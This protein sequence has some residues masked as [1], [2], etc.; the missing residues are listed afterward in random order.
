MVCTIVPNQLVWFYENKKYKTNDKGQVVDS[1]MYD[2]CTMSDVT[3]S[4]VDTESQGQNVDTEE[5]GVDCSTCQHADVYVPNTNPKTSTP[6]KSQQ[7]VIVSSQEVPVSSDE[8]INIDINT[9]MSTLG[10]N[11]LAIKSPNPWGDKGVHEISIEIVD[12]LND[13]EQST[14]LNGFEKHHLYIL[15]II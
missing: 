5:M 1:S 12:N 13:S 8:S 11:Q 3:G 10:E 14:E 7:I 9:E 2:D 15:T 4:N 6:V